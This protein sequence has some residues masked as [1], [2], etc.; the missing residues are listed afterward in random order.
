DHLEMGAGLARGGAGDSHA[1]TLPRGTAD[2]GV[3]RAG[4][5]GEPPP[6]QRQVHAFNLAP[7]D[8]RLQRG[9]G[10]VVASDD[11][12][13]AGALV[14][15]MDDAGSLGVGTAAEQVAELVDQGRTAVR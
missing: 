12:Q 3:D 14:E 2:R 1:V 7:L 9:M 13:A 11:E 15:A 4:A 8:L 5:R 6:R 10:L